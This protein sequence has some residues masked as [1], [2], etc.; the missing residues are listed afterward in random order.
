MSDEPF[1]EYVSE[2]K[3]RLVNDAFYLLRRGI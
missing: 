3:N 2:V 1:V